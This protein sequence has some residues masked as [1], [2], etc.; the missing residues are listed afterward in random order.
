V[1]GLLEMLTGASGRRYGR[2]GLW[3]D[4]ESARARRVGPQTRGRTRVASINAANRAEALSALSA[5]NPEL[6]RVLSDPD[7]HREPE[8]QLPGPHEFVWRYR[9]ELAPPLAAL[10]MVGVALWGHA[11]HLAGWPWALV[12]GAIVTGAWW[13]WRPLRP[14]RLAYVLAVGGLATAWL[15]IA[16]LAGPWHRWLL[17]PLLT[18]ALLAAVPWW[19]HQLPRPALAADDS[20]APPELRQ[21]VADLVKHWPQLAAPLGLGGVRIQPPVTI[22]EH[23]WGWWLRLPTLSKLTQRDLIAAAPRLD[24]AF[25]VRAGA[26][27]LEPDPGRADRLVLRVNVTN[28]LARAIPYEPPT[29]PRSVKDA[30]VLGPFEGGEDVEVVLQGRHLLMVGR[31]GSGKTTLQQVIL[32]ELLACRDAVV[33]VVDVSK[34]GARFKRLEAGLGWLAVE[35]D[36]ARAMFAAL[37]E[38]R[39]ARSRWRAETGEEVWPVSPEHPQLV[40]IVDEIADLMTYAGFDEAAASVAATGRED[41]ITL[42]AGSQRSTGR[43]L[44]GSVFIRTQC[45][46]RV[47]LAMDAPDVDLVLDRGARA[48][49]YQP[50]HFTDQGMFYLRTPEYRTPRPARGRLATKEQAA[51]ILARWQP[52][53]PRLDPISAPVMERYQ[54]QAA[55][56]AAGATVAERRLLELIDAAP[57]AGTTPADLEAS[58]VDL[59]VKRRWIVGKLSALKRQGR[60]IDVQR[61]RWR[62]AG[63]GDRPGLVVLHGDDE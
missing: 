26:T 54:R 58:M 14:P 39:D 55:R 11:D 24:K 27:R 56:D 62:G 44:G 38:I 40:V 16:W 31:T 23:G 9:R 47:A 61:G 53:R 46:L 42:I 20:D 19:D 32:Y 7:D 41:G 34:H 13:V 35:A 25:R 8:K 51:A 6:A 21:R 1:K 5:H 3:Q 33:W 2:W 48:V 45:E 60:A 63:Q 28:P 18:G 37:R 30:V 57:A 50:E 49:G 52:H 4:A 29:E 15:L 22:D 12:M 59:G 10:V 17:V 36:E 43:E